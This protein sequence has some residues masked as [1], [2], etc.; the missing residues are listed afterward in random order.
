MIAAADA[1]ARDIIRDANA[2]AAED[3]RE[4]EAKLRRLEVERDAV[5]Q[6]VQNLKSVFER[7]QANLNIS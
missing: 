6:Y 3:I 7:L 2:K 1:E 5:S 4:A